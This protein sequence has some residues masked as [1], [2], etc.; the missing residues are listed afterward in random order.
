[1]EIETLK[2]HVEGARVQGT[3]FN[4]AE[5][6]AIVLMGTK[7]DLLLI[8]SSNSPFNAVPLEAVTGKTLK[9]LAKSIHAHTSYRGSTF[10]VSF[11][12]PP[13]PILPLKTYDS[14]PQGMDFSLGWSSSRQ[15]IDIGHALSLI[16]HVCTTL[17]A[18]G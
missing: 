18:E 15:A 11:G 4:I 3:H 17:Q 13:R 6:P 8:D 1:L 2:R 16:A 5:I 7:H 9:S 12:Y 14:I 10:L